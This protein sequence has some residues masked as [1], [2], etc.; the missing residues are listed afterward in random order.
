MKTM[1]LVFAHPS[2]ESFL[3]GGTVAKYAAMDY[4]IEL[5]VAT[6]GEKGQNG[7]FT[8]AHEQALADLRKKE[9]EAAAHVL[10]IRNVVFLSQP[11]GGLSTI[12][13]GTIEDPIYQKMEELKP[14]IVITHD[15]TGMN[16]DPDCI[17]V[18]FAT[19]FA[20]QKYVERIEELK[21]PENF[22]PGRGKVWK[23]AA[24]EQMF[25]A[26]DP[27]NKEPK[28]YFVCLPDHV[29]SYLKKMKMIPQE[30]F[31]KPFLGTKDKFITTAI[32]IDKTKIIKGK[33]LLC[34]ETQGAAVNQFIDFDNHPLHKQEHFILRMQGIHEVFMG[35]S[36]RVAEEL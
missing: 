13:P 33:A 27:E 10:G 12:S 7:T 22:K 34:H 20:F 29:A 32:D 14:D 31:D 3:V 17:K 30:S 1:L 15:T 8:W 19:T 5:I 4:K 36:D 23:E 6:N 21:H 26:L 18:C 24:R 35:K 16:N 2:D 25:G 11:D 28:L 9:L